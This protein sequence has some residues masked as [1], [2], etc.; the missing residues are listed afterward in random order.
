MIRP[1][2]EKDLPLLATI[3]KR[4]YNLLNIG[5][6]W[7]DE[8][9]FKLMEWFFK[10]QRDLFFVAKVGKKISGAVVGIIK[11]WWDGNH[12][13]DG[14]IFIDPPFQR[15]GIGSRLIKELFQE[16]KKK[17]KVVSWDTFTHIVYEHPLKWYKKMGFEEINNWK[18][19]SGDIN[20]VLTNISKE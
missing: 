11:P 8:T 5:E 15:H 10:E 1:V 7:S 18:M 2:S 12:L 20:R 3:Y 6:R 9:A 14:E 17:Y 13:T 19:I 16:A 4:A